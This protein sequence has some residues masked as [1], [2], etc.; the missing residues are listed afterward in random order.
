MNSYS[1]KQIKWGI[2]YHTTGFDTE[3][4]ILADLY[5]ASF[6]FS[7]LVLT[8]S[9]SLVLVV[10]RFNMLILCYHMMNTTFN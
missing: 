5:L 6:L 7:S 9:T 1:V 10:G 8:V 2:G 4:A 3:V